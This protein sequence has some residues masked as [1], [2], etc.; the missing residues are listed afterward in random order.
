MKEKLEELQKKSRGS[1]VG[2]ATDYGQ[3][4]Q[5]VGDR[6]P[7]PTLGPTQPLIQKIQAVPSRGVKLQGR[8]ADHSI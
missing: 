5:Q 8:E 2:I 6:V 4:D 7:R 1:A 3:G